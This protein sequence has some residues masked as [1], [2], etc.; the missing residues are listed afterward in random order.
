MPAST[1]LERAYYPT[2]ERIAR[3]IHDVTGGVNDGASVAA[4]VLV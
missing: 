1:V 3:L 2:P 4:E